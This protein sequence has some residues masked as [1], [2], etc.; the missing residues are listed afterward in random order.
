MDF[1]LGG[2]LTS[3]KM[4][5]PDFDL[6]SLPK[7]DAKT[8]EVDMSDL[9]SSNSPKKAS[10]VDLAEGISTLDGESETSGNFKLPRGPRCQEKIMTKSIEES[11]DSDQESHLP[12]KATSTEPYARQT[13]HD[14]PGELVG[15]VDSNGDDVSNG[16][17]DGCPQITILN[18]ILSGKEDVND[19]M[20]IGDGP[21]HQPSPFKN[22]SSLDIGS[23]RS[24]NGDKSM[25]D[26][27]ILAENDEPAKGDLDIGKTSAT[28]VS[29][30]T[31]QDI[32]SIKGNQNSNLKLPL[33]TQAR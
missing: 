12:E 25:S 7:I 2:D 21:N 32:L 4:D 3:F 6:S 23:S 26:T 31:P 14:F 8:K 33:S 20:M 19:K 17:N 15:G 10:K 22:A 1:G 30:K 11:D 18:T 16:R 27:D 29:R 9:D 28:L 13:T 24:C 5:M